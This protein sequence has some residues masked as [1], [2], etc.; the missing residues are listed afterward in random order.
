MYNQSD[1]LERT[2]NALREPVPNAGCCTRDTTQLV[3]YP[4]ALG[5]RDFQ[6]EFYS[7][8]NGRRVG[9]VEEAW[10]KVFN[11]LILAATCCQLNCL[12]WDRMSDSFYSIED[13]LWIV[14]V[15]YIYIETH[16]Q[17]LLSQNLVDPNLNSVCRIQKI[18]NCFAL[19]SLSVDVVVVCCFF[20]CWCCFCVQLAVS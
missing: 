20:C 4:M 7:S 18:H 19:P 9:W 17:H 5:V 15:I 2:R 3:C 1:N 10:R 6:R 8:F 13:S 11:L 14:R 12:D 16:T